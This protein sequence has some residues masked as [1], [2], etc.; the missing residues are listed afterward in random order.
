LGQRLGECAIKV[1]ELRNRDPER[2]RVHNILSPPV[3][4]DKRGMP[5]AGKRIPPHLT[6]VPLR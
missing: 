1:A 5:W 6:L 4:S 3:V 2:H